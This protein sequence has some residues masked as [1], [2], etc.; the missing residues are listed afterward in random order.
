[1]NLNILQFKI[2]EE[3]KVLIVS[4]ILWKGDIAG[5]SELL[6]LMEVEFAYEYID[7][8]NF[9]KD[10]ELVSYLFYRTVF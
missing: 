3:I 7:R 6:I 10:N 1:V 4:D 9:S 2:K 8:N 5:E